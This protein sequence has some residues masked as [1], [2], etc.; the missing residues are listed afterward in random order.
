MTRILLVGCGRMGGAL[1]DGWLDRGVPAHDIV[2]VEPQP[3]VQRAH[4]TVV[5][6]PASIPAD[7]EPT[8]VV[9]AV[10][11]QVMAETLPA[12]C[13]Y[14]TP[15]FLSIAAGKTLDFFAAH[16]GPDVAIVRAMP[17]TPAAV[18]R[19][20]TVAVAGPPVST[21]QR[22][23]CD[24]LLT[25]VG[26]V[27]WIEDEAL[28]DAVTAVSGSG[29]AYVYLLTE[30]MADAGR[31]AGLPDEIADRLARQTVVGAGEL[32][33]Q[34][35]E[36]PEQLRKNVTSPGGTTAAALAVLSAPGGVHS[37]LTNA[38]EAATQRSKELSG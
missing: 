19:G 33:R 5:A 21:A 11:P 37:L 28:M 35:P 31:Q 9:L 7:F 17:N 1:L 6:S 34:S 13:R 12:Y 14:A 16:L 22:Q 10:K 3:A 30:A 20:I 38:I 4:V 2:V 8:V 36:S 25:A 26:E 24:T 27:L 15:V 29:P 18:R 23:C 32:M